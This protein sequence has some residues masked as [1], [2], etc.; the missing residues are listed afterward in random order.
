MIFS[1]EPV[2]KRKA[3]SPKLRWLSS[4]AK[5]FGIRNLWTVAREREN[6]G[7]LPEAAKIHL[8]IVEVVMKMTIIPNYYIECNQYILHK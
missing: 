8:W 6:S 7:T 2:S 3:G 4:G 1:I 5:L